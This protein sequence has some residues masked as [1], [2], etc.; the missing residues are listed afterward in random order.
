MPATTS[1]SAVITTLYARVNGT[2]VFKNRLGRKLVAI[3]PLG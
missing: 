2:V 3:E 1:V